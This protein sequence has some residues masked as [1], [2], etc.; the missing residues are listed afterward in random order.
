MAITRNASESL[1][2]LIFG[3]DL[4]PGDEV[5]Q[6]EPELPADDHVLGAAR[7]ARRHRP[8][9]DQ[10]PRSAAVSGRPSSTRSA[11]AITPRTRVIEV[12]H[13]TNLTGQILP[14]REIVRARPRAR[15]RGL[16]R[17]RP[18]VRALPVQARRAR[19]RLLRDEPPQVALRPDRH[20]VP[21]RPQGQASR[22]SGRS[23]PR[24]RRW[25]RTSASTRRSARIRPPTTTPS[26]WR[27]RST[28]AS[29]PSARPRGCATS[30]TAGPTA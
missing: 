28:A 29:A 2:N 21:L 30:A 24:R 12:T 16:R 26:R 6:H 11:Q 8:Q 10:L 17:R 25:T 3:I 4:K 23:W 7:P 9:A 18:R 13:I 14:V 15:H 20:G 1:E 27:S 19:V 5:I 22:A